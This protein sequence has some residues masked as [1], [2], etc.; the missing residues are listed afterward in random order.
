MKIQKCAIALVGMPGSGKSIM[1]SILQDLGVP[2]INMG[3]VIREEVIKKGLQPNPKE[4]GKIMLS[5]REDFGMDVV[6]KR[7]IPKI[8]QISEKVIV[9]DG[10]RNIEEVNFFKKCAIILLNLQFVS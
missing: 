5:M 6:A 3:D 4:I 10:I 9:I 8:R 1:A 2:T 7:C